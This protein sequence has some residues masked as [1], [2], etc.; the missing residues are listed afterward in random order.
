MNFSSNSIISAPP[1]R[2]VSSTNTVVSMI[3]FRICL[4]EP[5]TAT[6][7]VIFG[8]EKERHPLLLESGPLRTCEKNQH[9]AREGLAEVRASAPTKCYEPAATQKNFGES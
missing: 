2:Q 3:L 1:A 5:M 6:V 4:P 7:H 8:H 9:R